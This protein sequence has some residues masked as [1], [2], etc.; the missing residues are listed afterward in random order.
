MEWVGIVVIMSDFFG[1]L[2][3]G[4]A[5]LAEKKSLN[6]AQHDNVSKWQTVIDAVGT[7]ELHAGVPRSD[8]GK[9][10][11]TSSDFCRGNVAKYEYSKIPVSKAP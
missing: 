10:T 5:N 1:I 3:E 9:C 4:E 6:Y 2:G 8:S 7:W 11:H